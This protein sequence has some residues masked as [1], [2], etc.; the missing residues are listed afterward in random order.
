MDDAD[1]VDDDD[2]GNANVIDDDDELPL[3]GVE[4]SSADGRRTNS[5]M[6]VV[7]DEDEDEDEDGSG[8]DEAEDE[9]AGAPRAVGI[10]EP[11]T[12]TDA[13]AGV[14]MSSVACAREIFQTLIE[15]SCMPETG[16]ENRE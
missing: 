1:G 9:A 10:R 5:P 7:D 3:F 16:N 15:C 6:A 11:R 4:T 14:N 12:E 2:E 13:D 8:M